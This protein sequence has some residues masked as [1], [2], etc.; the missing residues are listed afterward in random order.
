[1]SHLCIF[2]NTSIENSGTLAWIGDKGL[3]PFRYLFNGRT[4]RVQPCQ[5]DQKTEIYS[6]SSF[7]KRG[8]KHRCRANKDLKS[9][10]TGMIKTALAVVFLIPGFILGT[11]FKGLA[12]LFSDVKEKHRLTKEYLKPIDRE[13]GSA[14]KPIQSL[15]HL[16]QALRLER[17]SDPQNHPT[18]ALIIHGDG[19]LTINEDPGILIFNPMKLILEGVKIS[20]KTQLI[21]N[22]N[23]A[24]KISKTGNWKVSK[25]LASIDDALRTIAPWRSWFS[26][27]RYHMIFTVSRPQVLITEVLPN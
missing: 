4:I 24:D 23:F 2:L 7:H 8:L 3:A 10:S 20:P 25:P 5:S 16:G 15:S 14:S 9:S 26:Y 17:Q 1:M 13:I 18:H 21:G 6:V 12:H 22:L 19:L 11:A 27:R